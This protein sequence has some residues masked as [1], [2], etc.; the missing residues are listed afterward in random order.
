[1]GSKFYAYCVTSIHRHRAPVDLVVV[2]NVDRVL[3]ARTRGGSVT[4]LESM[5]LEVARTQ[6]RHLGSSA[7]LQGWRLVFG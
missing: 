6:Q 4:S 5:H 7:C 3:P 2:G 1:M